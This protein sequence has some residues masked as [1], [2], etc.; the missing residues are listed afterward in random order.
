MLARSQAKLAL[1]LGLPLNVHSRSAGHHAITLLK[2]VG[3]AKS[4][5]LHAFDGKAKYAVDAVSSWLE[6]QPPLCVW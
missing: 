1:E 4:C 3:A 6:R 2:E 5:V